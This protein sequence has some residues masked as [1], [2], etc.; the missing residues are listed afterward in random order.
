M[1]ALKG[2]RPM[3]CD[4]GDGS[5]HQITH[6]AIVCLRPETKEKNIA[7]GPSWAGAADSTEEGPC[8]SKTLRGEEKRNLA[9]GVAKA[10]AKCKHPLGN[11]AIAVHARQLPDETR[12]V[13][14]AA[15]ATTRRLVVFLPGAEATGAVRG[16]A[17]SRAMRG[18]PCW[19]CAVGPGCFF[20][21]LAIVFVYSAREVRAL[22]FSYSYRFSVLLSSQSA[23]RIPSGR[24]PGAQG[25]Y[26]CTAHDPRRHLL[27]PSLGGSSQ[28]LVPYLLPLAERFLPFSPA[29]AS[30]IAVPSSF[31][32]F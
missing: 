21:C 19:L 13:V 12:C 6:R 9:W 30:L 8:P 10:T 2:S 26:L 3:R 32:L 27:R 17:R 23:G 29:R 7:K 15:S 16:A 18:H 25:G 28:A 22:L 31:L 14:A 24:E 5:A 20:V 11:P 4:R 1:M